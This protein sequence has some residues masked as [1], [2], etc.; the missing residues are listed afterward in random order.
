VQGRG[1]SVRACKTR[2]C[3]RPL[4]RGHSYRYDCWLDL[5]D[6]LAEEVER[7]SFSASEIYIGRT[8][9]ADARRDEHFEDSGRPHLL[10]LHGSHD[11][12]EVCAIEAALIRRFTRLR[13]LANATDASLGGARG[14]LRNYVYVSWRRRR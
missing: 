9:D 2:G 11:L 10:V 14:D 1:V 12:D 4:R 5:I 13:K 3:R 6:L 7:V 8:C